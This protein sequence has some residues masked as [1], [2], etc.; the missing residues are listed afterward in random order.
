MAGR[1]L[2]IAVRE[3]NDTTLDGA[4]MPL[5]GLAAKMG[6]GTGANDVGADSP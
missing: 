5:V 1:Q 3:T 6:G 2:R 4:V